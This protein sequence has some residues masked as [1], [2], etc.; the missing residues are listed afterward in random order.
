LKRKEKVKPTTERAKRMQRKKWSD[1]KH[2]NKLRVLND[3]LSLDVSSMSVSSLSTV[4]LRTS[5]PS[6][7]RA[8]RVSAELFRPHTSTPTVSV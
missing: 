2:R 1:S 8:L 6:T 7:S 3:E 5:V 4:S